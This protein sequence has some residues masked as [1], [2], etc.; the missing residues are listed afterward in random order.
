MVV[1]AAVISVVV[2]DLNGRVAV[3]VVVVLHLDTM[4]MMSVKLQR[5]VD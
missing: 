3:V 1:V 5:V 2:V 4:R